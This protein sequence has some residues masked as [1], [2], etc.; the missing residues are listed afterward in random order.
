MYFHVLPISYVNL[1]AILHFSIKKA[2]NFFPNPYDLKD[3]LLINNILRM[4]MN[5]A[6]YICIQYLHINSNLYTTQ[7]SNC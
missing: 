5:V 7:N 2:S 3:F 1:G 4:F 6:S